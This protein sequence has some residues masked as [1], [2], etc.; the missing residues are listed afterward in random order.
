MAIRPRGHELF[1][2]HTSSL[3]RGG[4]QERGT[5]NP[6]NGAQHQ[7]SERADGHGERCLRQAD[8]ARAGQESRSREPQRARSIVPP[9]RQEPDQVE[10]EEDQKAEAEKRSGSP[11]EVRRRAFDKCNDGSSI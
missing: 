4:P 2:L 11:R 8:P 1:S 3:H 6:Q 10:Q 9:P 5:P 7:A